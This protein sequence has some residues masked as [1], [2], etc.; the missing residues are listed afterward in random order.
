MWRMS[1]PQGTSVSEY[2][3]TSQPCRDPRSFPHHSGGGTASVTQGSLEGWALE[4]H[5]PV[6]Q[7]SSHWYIPPNKTLYST[8]H[9]QESQ[10]CVHDTFENLRNL[11]RDST[12]TYNYHTINTH[13]AGFCPICLLAVRSDATTASTGQLD[14]QLLE[15][16]WVDSV[17]LFSHLWVTLLPAPPN[18]GL[19]H[20]LDSL[21]ICLFLS[22]LWWTKT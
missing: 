8:V 21:R 22:V 1:P 9:I 4:S 6:L 12:S 5:D 19:W 10:S 7:A 11:F 13:I 2:H 17:H 15:Y 16:L 3:C 18:A 14:S 20:H